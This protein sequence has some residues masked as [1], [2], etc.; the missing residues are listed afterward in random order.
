VFRELFIGLTVLVMALYAVED[1]VE[2]ELFVHTAIIASRTR[3]RVRM[4]TVGLDEVVA[5]ATSG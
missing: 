3:A 2:F 1:K 5:S 4:V